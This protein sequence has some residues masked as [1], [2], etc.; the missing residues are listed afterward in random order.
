MGDYKWYY[1]DKNHKAW[2][3][4]STEELAEL[5]NTKAISNKTYVWKKGFEDWVRFKDI[6]SEELIDLSLPIL[7]EPI[8]AQRQVDLTDN[9]KSLD[10]FSKLETSP[11][12]EIDYAAHHKVVWVTDKHKQNV[13]NLTQR[14]ITSLTEQ[15]KLESFR[16]SPTK[17]DGLI[18]GTGEADF[19][20]G[21]VP[22]E[23]DYFNKT[24]QLIDVPGIEG[25][26]GKYEYLVKQ[27]IEKAH[28]IIYVNG[29]N[30]KPEDATAIKIKNYINQYAKVYVICNVRGKADNYEFEEDQISLEKTHGGI[31][32][33]LNQTL[34]VLK[35]NLGSELIEGGQCLQG[36]LAFSSLA[37]DQ[38]E[39][40]TTISSSRK[41]LIKSQ[42]S[43]KQDFGSLDKMRSFSQVNELEDK[44]ISKC[45]TFEQDIFESNKRKIVRKIEEM[46]DVIQEQLQIHLELQNRIKKELDIGRDSI[47]NILTDFKHNLSSK[48]DNA[49]SSAFS[50]IIDG[51]YYV[52]ENNFKDKD[53]ISSK[54]ENIVN[55]ESNTL[56]RELDR[57]KDSLNQQFQSNLKEA[58]QRTG[59]NIEQVQMNFNLEYEQD[60]GFSIEVSDISMFDASSI[61]KGLLEI[62]GMAAM[63]A[64]LGTAFPI[65]GNV[66]GA[67][68]G[69]LLGVFSF[70][71]KVFSSKQSKINK[72]QSKFRADVNTA[73]SKFKSQVRYSVDQMINYLK[74]DIENNVISRTYMEYEKMKDVGH[75]LTGQVK[76]LSDLSNQIKR[77]EYGTV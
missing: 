30:K 58:I 48:S 76:K 22:Y 70:L 6:L 75:I 69:L 40:E 32:G 47:S 20:K 49:I 51:G 18:I 9:L 61:S 17:P 59:R 34:T 3:T 19:T 62:G 53:L 68:G 72:A 13:T 63:G 74:Q 24:F 56:S 7:V 11:L 38:E 4:Y 29:T 21:S 67:V 46:V 37:F 8:G 66:I 35:H 1:L 10:P 77:K 45:S 43:Y 23:F 16:L 71:F 55:N 15:R 50:R 39:K 5:Y 31:D 42:K 14:L 60:L 65:I 73:Q 12:N 54:I 2:G 41:D 52:I 26:E 44:I 28:L 57:I 36:L 64:G 33:V 27:A 25:D